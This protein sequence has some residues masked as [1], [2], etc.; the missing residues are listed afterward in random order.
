MEKIRKKCP[1]KLNEKSPQKKPTKAPIMTPSI[2]LGSSKITN[3]NRSDKM[4]AGNMTGLENVRNLPVWRLKRKKKKA[5]IDINLNALFINQ[6]LRQ[7]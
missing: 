5:M 7:L 4:I 1:I 6:Y 3:N 2:F